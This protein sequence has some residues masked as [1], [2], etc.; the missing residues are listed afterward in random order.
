MVLPLLSF[1]GCH[2]QTLLLTGTRK[3]GAEKNK[4]TTVKQKQAKTHGV[5][6]CYFWKLDKTFFLFQKKPFSN[7]SF[8]PQVLLF[9]W[10]TCVMLICIGAGAVRGGYSTA[11]RKHVSSGM[12]HRLQ[13]LP[14]YDIACNCSFNLPSSAT[15]L[16]YLSLW[17][18]VLHINEHLS[19]NFHS[20]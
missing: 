14:C 8:I 6:L 11:Y 15:D 3:A 19:N 7:E 4:G 1:P 18:K 10:W 12:L 2:C 17:C 9:S 20:S 13:H 5:F 16:I